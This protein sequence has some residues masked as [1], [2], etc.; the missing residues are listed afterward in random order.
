MNMR[1]DQ[2]FPCKPPSSGCV[3]VHACDCSTLPSLLCV[4]SD[5]LYP[6][7]NSS[8]PTGPHF[9]ML[10]TARML[11]WARGRQRLVKGRNQPAS[12]Q[13]CRSSSLRVSLSSSNR[14]RC[15]VVLFV[16]CCEGDAGE[17]LFLWLSA[18]SLFLP[19]SVSLRGLMS[20]ACPFCFHCLF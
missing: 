14:S 15:L 9:S 19:F 4:P 12:S 13:V 20:C 5:F 8:P 1:R 10:P 2:A 3:C 7:P 16:H 17:H 11:G 6:K 18:P